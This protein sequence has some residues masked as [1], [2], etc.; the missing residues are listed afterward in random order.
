MSAQTTR[1]IYAA[2]I[3]GFSVIMASA[4]ARAQSDPEPDAASPP[5]KGPQVGAAADVAEAPRVGPPTKVTA[6]PPSPARINVEFYG[7]LLP[8]LEVVGSSGATPMGFTGGA[9]QVEDFQY[10]G[11]NA[12]ERVRMTA[13]TSGIGFRGTLELFEN[14]KVTWQ[15]ESAVPINGA[16]PNT[17][18]SRNSHIGFTGGWGTLIWGIWDTPWKWAT[19]VTINPINGSFVPDYTALLST[20]G[21][22][23]SPVNATSLLQGDLS[24]APFYRR[25]SNSV[26]YWSPTVAGFSLRLMGSTNQDRPNPAEALVASNPYLFSGYLGFDGGGLR[27]RAAYERHHDFFGMYQLGALSSDAATT[28]TD[29][30]YQLTVQ[31]A[32]TIKPE[33]RTRVVGTGELL[34]YKSTDPVADAFDQYSRP[35]FYAL[36]EQTVFGHHLWGAYGQAFE[37]KCHRVGGAACSTVGLGARMV[38]AGYLYA[39]NDAT[40]IYLTGYRIINDVSSVHTTFPAL[41]PTAPGSDVT[42]VGMGIF[43]SFGVKLAR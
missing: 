22:G 43:Y 38:S 17:I 15:V 40:D 33:L 34:S 6:P 9:S 29:E 42:G 26:Q 8:F 41:N 23:V 32:L 35:A 10:S 37:G 28:S 21:F 5:P 19:L 1:T 20:P 13:G 31:Y 3:I 39:F 12:P 14:L 25:E 18:A 16:G 24:R 4:V 2:L 7:A 30:G 27:V 36:L 11:I